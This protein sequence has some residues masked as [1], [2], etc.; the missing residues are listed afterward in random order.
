[1]TGR[2]MRIFALV[3]LIV[4]L[5]VACAGNG[6]GTDTEEQELIAAGEVVFSENCARC[7]GSEGEGT[8]GAAPPLAGN[9][10][11]TGDPQPVI[12]TVLNGR[13]AMPPFRDE[14]DDQ[15]IAAVVSFI[16]N[17]WGNEAS[18]VAPEDVAAVR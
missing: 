3:V 5:S 4:G 12:E 14:L 6:D 15:E 8:E 9:E 11:V 17:A 18:T 2:G 16:R 1:M 7:H 10:T 13:S